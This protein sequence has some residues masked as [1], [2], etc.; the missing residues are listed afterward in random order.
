MNNPTHFIEVYKIG[1]NPVTKTTGK[2]M[3]IN[4]LEKVLS[5][6]YSKSTLE[7]IA[8]WKLKLK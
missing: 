7:T 4:I 3:H 1:K 2:P 8:I 6:T 5:S